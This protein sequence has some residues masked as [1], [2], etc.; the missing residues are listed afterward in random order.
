MSWT[1]IIR[2][3]KKKK[4][5]GHRTNYLSGAPNLHPPHRFRA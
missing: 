3:R 1:I 4:K 5:G 2:F